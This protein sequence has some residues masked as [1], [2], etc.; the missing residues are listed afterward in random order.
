MD[1][2]YTTVKIYPVAKPL[3]I[4]VLIHK[5]YKILLL[6]PP[7]FQNVKFFTQTKFE[8]KSFNPQNA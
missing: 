7:D 1:W 4:T 6:T 2:V 5:I 3:I 8:E